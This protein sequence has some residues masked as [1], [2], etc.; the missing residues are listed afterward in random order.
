MCRRRAGR[1]SK[2]QKCFQHLQPLHCRHTSLRT[3]VYWSECFRSVRGRFRRSRQ[4]FQVLQTRYSQYRTKDC[5][6]GRL[7]SLELEELPAVGDCTC[8]H[9]LAGLRHRPGLVYFR[10]Y[11]HSGRGKDLYSSQRGYSSWRFH[12]IRCL[13]SQRNFQRSWRQ[14]RF[15]LHRFRSCLLEIPRKMNRSMNR[16]LNCCKLQSRRTGKTGLGKKR[17]RLTS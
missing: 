5:L 9:L 17:G 15:L 14:E 4:N 8:F 2:F 6:A 10:E 1:Y 11:C 12:R 13:R 3:P 7:R 16:S